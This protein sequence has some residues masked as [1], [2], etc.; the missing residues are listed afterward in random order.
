MGA[1]NVRG[2]TPDRPDAPG[3]HNRAPIRPRSRRVPLV[4]KYVALFALL[5]SVPLIAVG[6]VQLNASYQDKKD[7]IRDLQ[8]QQA[9]SAV[10]SIE[11][12]LETS[13]ERLQQAS[14]PGLS[15]DE[16]QLLLNR[17]IA[18][19]LGFTD[20]YYVDLRG[21]EQLHSSI[22]EAPERTG[23]D[24]SGM[25]F[26][27]RAKADFLYYGPPYY[28]LNR[29]SQGAT[30]RLLPAPGVPAGP[31]GALVGGRQ[32]SVQIAVAEEPPGKGV[33]VGVANLS[34]LQEV[35]RKSRV[36]DSGYAYLLDRGG[37]PL[38]HPDPQIPFNTLS[39]QLA[40]LP[41]IHEALDA[42]SSP[43]GDLTGRDRVG[44]KVLSAYA[45]VEPV[46]WRV[47][48]ERELSE[49]YAPIR[50]SVIRIGILLAAF[51]AAAVLASFLLARRLVRPIKAMQR[52]AARIGAG[53]Y[54]ERVE[55]QRSDELGDLA[56]ELNR[57]A[58]SLE[59]THG[60]L[61][62]KVEERTRELQATLAELAE[63]SR[64]L[65]IASRHK[66]E[67]LANMSHELRTPLNAIVGFSQV[68]REQLF[69]D[70]NEKQLE[71]LEDILSSANHLLSLINDILDLSKVE[72]GQVELEVAEFSLREALERGIVMVRERAVKD[73]VELDLD[74]DASA[75]IVEADERRIR[76]VIFNLLSNAVKFTPGGGRV[77]VSTTRVD[78]EVRVA[79][80][81]TGPGIADD[82]RERIFEE[83]QQARVGTD[84]KPEGTGLGL[85]LSRKL[86][87]LHGGRI[88]VE[89]DVGV[90]STF[91]FTLPKRHARTVVAGG[92]E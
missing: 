18:Y 40:S 20:V 29:A 41:Q 58:A 23:A 84:N 14:A 19:P 32:P 39:R 66:S 5:V 31:D 75:E 36:G 10:I 15:L 63:K 80:Q 86:V 70:L 17:L 71:Y 42:G 38:H 3:D 55:L 49:A 62:E 11:Q 74:V 59:E 68:L 91:V 53:E 30:D 61:E 82:D 27:R 90:G 57:M 6:L 37:R 7:A 50:A 12:F 79:V 73:G 72:A 92:T 2:G 43:E 9:R 26:F 8:R 13:Q 83:F 21:R 69:G 47:F 34:S 35:I 48:V 87:E 54:G 60:L 33:V 28:P 24:R 52:T 88:W 1:E 76:Q 44:R 45:T 77:E 51:L 64:E 81:D 89:S 16:R 78:G 46:G 56:D 85:A 4:A 65:E 22:F 67:F 25:A